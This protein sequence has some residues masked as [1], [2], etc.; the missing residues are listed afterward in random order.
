MRPDGP[1]S[2]LTEARDAVRQ[3][4]EQGDR[5]H[6]TVVVESGSYVLDRPLILEAID[7][8]LTF[9]AEQESSPVLSGGKPILDWK[10]EGGVWTTKVDPAWRFEALWVNG[11]RATRARTPNSGFVQAISQPTEQLPNVGVTGDITRTMLRIEAE[12]AKS[13]GGL[14]PAERREVNVVV[15]FTWDVLR[16]RLH[17]LD[18]NDGTLQFAGPLNRQ[19]FSLA[20]FHAVILENYHT[21]LDSPGEWFLAL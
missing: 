15:Y 17:A 21:A 19:F 13:L 9:E 18:S 20:P 16:H 6:A 2:T 1:I 14:S 3:A 7:S 4:R 8:D 11:K 12:A 5:S 10:N